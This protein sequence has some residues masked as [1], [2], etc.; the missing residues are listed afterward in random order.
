V[1]ALFRS[2]TL[3]VLVSKGISSMPF[4]DLSTGF[5]AVADRRIDAFVD[6]EAQLSYSENNLTTKL[7][8]RIPTGCSPP[9][10]VPGPVRSMSQ[11]WNTIMNT[12]T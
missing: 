12:K 1:G 7:W 3:D 4:D 2:E 8:I 9:A 6:N 11:T 10:T 5:Q